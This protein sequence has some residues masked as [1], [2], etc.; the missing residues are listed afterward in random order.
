VVDKNRNNFSHTTPKELRT[1]A[2]DAGSRWEEV[3]RKS[4]LESKIHKCKSGFDQWGGRWGKEGDAHNETYRVRVEGSTAVLG[5]MTIGD[6]IVMLTDPTVFWL[7]GRYLFLFS[8]PMYL[9]TILSPL[10][11]HRFLS[12]SWIFKISTLIFLTIC[13]AAWEDDVAKG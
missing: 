9:D 10:I 11:V 2:K 13:T 8:L 6:M 5:R 1:V 12:S 4:A 3:I 7:V